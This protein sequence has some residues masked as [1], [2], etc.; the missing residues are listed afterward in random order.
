MACAGVEFLAAEF[1]AGGE[2]VLVIARIEASADIEIGQGLLEF[3][4]AG[5][6]ARR[7]ARA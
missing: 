6:E 4:A 2:G 7:T 3:I 5:I 1:H